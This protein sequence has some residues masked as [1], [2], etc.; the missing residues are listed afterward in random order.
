MTRLIAMAI[1]SGIA[2]SAANAANPDTSAAKVSVVGSDLTNWSAHSAMDWASAS[3]SAGLV[4]LNCSIWVAIPQTSS[5]SAQGGA[6]VA[7]PPAPLEDE[8]DDCPVGSVLVSGLPP[9]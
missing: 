1:T 8:L 3:A 6:T 5:A 7:G 2:S 4:P 9:T